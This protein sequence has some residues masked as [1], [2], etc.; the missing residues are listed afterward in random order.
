MSDTSLTKDPGFCGTCGW[1]PQACMCDEDESDIERGVDGCL[2]GVPWDED[3][4]WCDDEEAEAF[5]E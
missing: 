3:C 4:E 5:N 1:P 2:H